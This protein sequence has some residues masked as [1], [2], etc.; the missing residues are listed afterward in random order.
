MVKD[1]ADGTFIMDLETFVKSF[2]AF[3]V[4]H[5][6]SK[7][8]VQRWMKLDDPTELNDDGKAEHRFNIASAV[9]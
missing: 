2:H 4:S 8:G 9:D 1:S 3:T 5:D 6:V 7:H